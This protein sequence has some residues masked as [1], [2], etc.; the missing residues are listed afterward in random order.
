VGKG[1]GFGRA[2]SV[3]VLVLCALGAQPALAADPVQ[4]D[5]WALQR[6]GAPA[7]WAQGRGQGITVG[8][9]DSGVDLHHEDLAGQV[10]GGVSCMRSLGDPGNCR[11]SAQ[12]DDGH[13]THVAGILAAKADNG[14][15]I[16]GVAPAAKLLAVRALKHVCLP[17]PTGGEKC[18]AEGSVQDARAG[19]RWAVDHG[20]QVVNLSVADDVLTRVATGSPLADEIQRAWQKGVIVVVAAGNDLD[21]S[22]GSGYGELPLLVVGATSFDNQR[23]NY[24]NSVGD[25]RWGLTA[26]GG[27]GDREC[28]AHNVVSTY[29]RSGE[30]NAYACLSGTSMAAPHVAGAAAV[31]LST[32]LS[33]RQTVDRILGTT[34]DLGAAGYDAVFGH[35][36]LNLARATSSAPPR[37][38]AQVP[39]AP[40]STAAPV[41]GAQGGG[42][43]ATVPPANPSAPAASGEPRPVPKAG[44]PDAN[45]RDGERAARPIPLP[46]AKSLPWWLVLVAITLIGLNLTWLAALRRRALE[47]ARLRVRTD[48]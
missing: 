39:A 36:M 13:G 4:P 42:A 37:A 1:K 23:A 27:T 31:L 9:V 28:P 44:A 24:S 3:V 41:S 5:Q 33:P 2:I 45:H 47:R 21:V 18:G 34:D 26:P 38:P 32:G 10:A 30:K 12:D 40:T 25:A 8:V 19:L 29:W 48:R 16:A 17:L 46:D 7:A 11:G 15:G 20:A 22:H 14:V 43:T 35:G 6:V